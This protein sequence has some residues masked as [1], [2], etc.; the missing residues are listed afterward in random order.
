MRTPYDLRARLSSLK[1][2]AT[3]VTKEISFRC[4]GEVVGHSGRQARILRIVIRGCLE[5]AL[6]STECSQ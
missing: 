4:L 1:I 5:G 6:K 3:I 2:T